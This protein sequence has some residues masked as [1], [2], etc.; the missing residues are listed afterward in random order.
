MKIF[1]NLAAL[2][3]MLGI[4]LLAV[5]CFSGWQRYLERDRSALPL[6]VK[7]LAK[8]ETRIASS[9]RTRVMAPGMLLREE[10]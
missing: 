10:E 4:F 5:V 9:G 6:D 1:S 7:A 8:A 3:L 2:L